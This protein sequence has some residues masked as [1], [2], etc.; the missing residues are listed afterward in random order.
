MAHFRAVIQGSR[1]EASRLGH[2]STGLMVKA[3]TWGWD[4]VVSVRHV[5]ARAAQNAIP[6]E[7]GSR[8]WPVEAH[9]VADVELVRHDRSE[10]RPAFSVNLTTGEV[11]K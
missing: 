5:E 10:R 6:G 7:K 9:D 1:G 8:A 11:I 4:L 3:Q 2:K